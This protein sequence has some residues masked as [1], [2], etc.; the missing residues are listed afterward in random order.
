VS[1]LDP[2]FPGYLYNQSWLDDYP[3]LLS[4]DSLQLSLQLLRGDFSSHDLTLETIGQ[5][6]Y[7]EF[8]HDTFN[9]NIKEE[10]NSGKTWKDTLEKWPEQKREEWVT[11]RIEKDLMPVIDRLCHTGIDVMVYV[12]P[13]SRLY[14]LEQ[15]SMAQ[16]VIY[17]PRQ[18]LRHMQSCENIRL[19]A[20]DTMAFVEDLNYYRDSMHYTNETSTWLLGRMAAGQNRLLKETIADYEDKWLDRINAHHVFSSYPSKLSWV[21]H[22]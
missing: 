21:S 19:Y 20:F 10:L 13:L 1:R 2:V 12:P 9:D 16:D 5:S 14:Y 15:D 22:D 18:V 11:M 8:K 17:M 6:Y 4:L 3:Y 7:Q